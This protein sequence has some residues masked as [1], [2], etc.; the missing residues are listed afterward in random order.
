MKPV[1]HPKESQGR[2]VVTIET[3]L[4]DIEYELKFDKENIAKQFVDS[5]RQQAAIGEADE[6]RKVSIS[7]V[8][9]TLR[10]GGIC[11]IFLRSSVVLIYMDVIR[12]LS[13]RIVSLVSTM[14]PRDCSVLDTESYSTRERQSSSLK[15]LLPRRWKISQKRKKN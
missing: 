5:F 4:G 8:G 12:S 3:N 9:H 15:R 10:R 13:F 1:L 6:I 2:F 7:F 11:A 14:T